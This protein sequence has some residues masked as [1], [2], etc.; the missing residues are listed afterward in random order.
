MAEKT[1]PAAKANATPRKHKNPK[2]LPGDVF[3]STFPAIQGAGPLGLGELLNGHET[4]FVA[5]DLNEA[6]KLAKARGLGEEIVGM[7][8]T[9]PPW[10]LPS[11]FAEAANWPEAMHAACW[12][13]F[14]A[15]RNK[16]STPEELLSDGGVIHNLAHMNLPASQVERQGDVSKRIAAKLP[17]QLRAI[18]ERTPGYTRAVPDPRAMEYAR[19]GKFSDTSVMEA[20]DAQGD[21]DDG[22]EGRPE[23]PTDLLKRLFEEMESRQKAKSDA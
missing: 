2:A 8:L 21:Y 19:T 16:T 5:A 3:I 23:R 1:S 14:V 11:E 18:E 7:A 17:G 20:H 12:L 13:G 4:Q 9:D 22:D 15:L 6:K 10:V